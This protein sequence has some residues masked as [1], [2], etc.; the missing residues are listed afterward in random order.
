[1][2]TPEVDPRTPNE[3][4]YLD[5]RGHFCLLVLMEECIHVHLKGV[6]ST[7]VGMIPLISPFAITWLHSQPSDSS[8]SEAEAQY[9]FSYPGHIASNTSN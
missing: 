6:D 9:L 1:M 5:H 8:E 2:K 7:N 3:Q 4:D